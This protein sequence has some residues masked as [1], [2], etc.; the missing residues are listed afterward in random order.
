MTPTR[1]IPDTQQFEA[2]NEAKQATGETQLKTV[3]MVGTRKVHE[4]IYYYLSKTFRARLEKYQW[5]SATPAQVLLRLRQGCSLFLLLY[6]ILLETNGIDVDEASY[7]MSE[8]DARVQMIVNMVNLGGLT[9]VDRAEISE[10]VH[11]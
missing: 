11:R 6:P 1:Q 2:R 9:C 5:F 8:S 10:T 4:R 7:E 3:E